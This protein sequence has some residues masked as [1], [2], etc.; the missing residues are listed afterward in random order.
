MAKRVT[1]ADCVKLTEAGL[2]ITNG[3]EKQS[4]EGFLSQAAHRAAYIQPAKGH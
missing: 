3:Y 1:T 4:T 2:V